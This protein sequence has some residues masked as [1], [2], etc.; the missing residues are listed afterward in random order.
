MQQ[1]ASRAVITDAYLPSGSQVGVTLSGTGYDAYTNVCYTASGTGTSQSWGGSDDVLLSSSAATL[2]SYYPYSS[3]VSSDA[4]PVETASQT[5]Y[6]YGTPVT[7]ISEAKASTGVTLNHAL[8]NL[9]I[10]VAKGSHAGT[11]V[12]SKISVAGAGIA[13]GGTFNAATATPGYTAYS[14]E[15]SLVERTLTSTLGSP[16]DLMVVPTGTSSAVTFTVT[17][18]GTDYTATSS[19]VALQMGAAY[20]Y[21]LALNSSFLT[22]SSFGV[23]GWSTGTGGAMVLDKVPDKTIYVYAV[24]PDF[25]LVDY[26]TATT[27]A[28]G[29]AVVAGN[30]KFMIAK[31]DAT[32]G[33]NNTWYWGENLYNKDVAGITNISTG[34]GYLPKPN[35]T[36][37]YTPYLSDDFTTWTEG[38]LSDFAGKANTAAI[39]K[40]YTEHSVS[41]KTRD[42]CSVLNMFNATS[43]GSNANKNDW[44]VP[45]CGQLGIMYLAKSDINAALGK[46]GGT[47][48]VDS[49]YWSSSEGESRYAWY[50]HFLDGYVYSNPKSGN[51]LVRFVRDI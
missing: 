7:G 34:N 32:D 23:A 36:Y 31:S 4:I 18:D 5:D 46:I 26:N 12:V 20:A 37:Q 16:V 2:Y 27:S 17:V 39:I 21:T 47:A 25:S 48:L 19:A 51:R 10:T 35:G 3:T 1:P 11:G 38:V 42:M 22:V 44:Y 50:V 9:K 41:M 15:G 49:Y 40:A 28:V 13:T 29:V 8:A 33:T 6:L 24:N 30:H 45:A 14:G 43:D